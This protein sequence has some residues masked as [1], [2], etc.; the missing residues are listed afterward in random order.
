M[1]TNVFAGSGSIPAPPNPW[2]GMAMFWTGFDGVEWDLTTGRSGVCMLP[3][4]RGLTMPPIV[5]HKST[6]ASVP[7]ARWRG[8]TT[9]EREVFWPVQLYHTSSSVNWVS[10]DRKFWDTLAPDKTG[11]WTVIQPNGSTRSLT[12]RFRD[13]GNAAFNTDPVMAGWA[14]YGIT[15]DAE[16]PYWEGGN[17]MTK[18]WRAASATQFFG[19]TGIVRISSGM[20]STKAKVTNFGDVPAYPI[21]T[22]TG[23]LS[24][25]TLTVAGRSINVGFDIPSGSTLVIDTRPT[26]LTAMMGGTDRIK[27]LGSSDFAPVP[28][29]VDVPVTLTI[30]GTGTI[31]MTFTPLYYRAW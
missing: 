23:P 5:H 12:L 30:T 7:G 3:G 14:N 2:P 24:S 10:R 1:A 4:V 21:W 8:F 27:G 29:G 6:S 20:E 9:Q 26:A 15:L 31:T 25:A 19:S 22:L 28:V 13:D 17:D 18:T 11:V 16:Q